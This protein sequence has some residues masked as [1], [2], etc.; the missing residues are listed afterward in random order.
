[1]VP[2]VAAPNHAGCEAAGCGGTMEV[3][4]KSKED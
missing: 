1:M 3:V 2:P 4:V